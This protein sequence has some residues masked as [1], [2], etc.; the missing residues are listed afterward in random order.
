[1]RPI[2]IACSTLIGVLWA[3][4]LATG[5]PMRYLIQS[6]PLLMA[7]ALATRQ[8]HAVKPMALALSTFWFLMQSVIGLF[9]LG[10]GDRAVTLPPIELVL[11]LAT[12]LAA[13]ALLVAALRFRSTVGVVSGLGVFV[14][15]GL[16]QLAAFLVSILPAI[17]TS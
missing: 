10:W 5:A 4:G 16:L 14:V 12:A 2:T 6:A 13:V 8:V 17:S 3:T 15:S 11:S 7:A 1:M 9:L